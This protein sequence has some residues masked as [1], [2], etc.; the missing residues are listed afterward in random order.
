MPLESV[1]YRYVPA[2][3]EVLFL[4]KTERCARNRKV[5]HSYF[6]AR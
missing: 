6:G 4:H 3:G 5:T 2:E 1:G